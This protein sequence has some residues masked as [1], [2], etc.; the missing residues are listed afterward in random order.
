MCSNDKNVCD[1]FFFIINKINFHQVEKKKVKY[2]ICLFVYCQQQNSYLSYNSDLY[3]YLDL[4][5]NLD[6]NLKI[7]T[8]YLKIPTYYLKNV[9]YYVSIFFKLVTYLRS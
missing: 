2:Y 5:W 3:E 8:Y 1:S 6:F 7:V 9:N 4:C